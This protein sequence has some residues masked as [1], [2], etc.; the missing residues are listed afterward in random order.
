MKVN[1]LWM[2][3][4]TFFFLWRR[5]PT[6]IG[7]PLSPSSWNS[8]IIIPNIFF[9]LESWSRSNKFT[10][11]NVSFLSSLSEVSNSRA[12]KKDMEV[13]LQHISTCRTKER[14]TKRHN[15][16]HGTKLCQCPSTGA[17]LNTDS[18][19]YLHFYKNTRNKKRKIPMNA[20]FPLIQVINIIGGL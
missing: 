3:S 1:I 7:F 19:H 11:T 18:G 13:P 2:F 16:G 20:S 8:N 17:I 5:I 12:Q 6:N 4:S 10:S 14:I 9:F 15:R